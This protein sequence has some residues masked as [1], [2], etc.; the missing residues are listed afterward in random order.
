MMGGVNVMTDVPATF[1]RKPGKISRNRKD[2]RTAEC[3]DLDSPLGEAA[4][5]AYSAGLDLAMIVGA[6]FVLIAA[7]VV[8]LAMPSRPQRVAAGTERV[9][10]S[11]EIAGSSE[12]DSVFTP[13]M[14]GDELARL[15]SGDRRTL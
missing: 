8:F 5:L 10:R 4:R 7:I 14:L 11:S 13:P 6:A 9:D 1:D 12:Q 15:P 3:S 2:A